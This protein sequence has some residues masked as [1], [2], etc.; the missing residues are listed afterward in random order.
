M[1]KL[2][3]VLMLLVG[4]QQISA[5]ATSTLKSDCQQEKPTRYL[6]GLTEGIKTTLMPKNVRTSLSNDKI[7]TIACKNTIAKGYSYRFNLMLR[8]EIRKTIQSK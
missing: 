2:F 1:K 4:V 7:V 3:I 6:L 8:A 5:D